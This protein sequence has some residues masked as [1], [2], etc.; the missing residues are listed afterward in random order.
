MEVSS[1]SRPCSRSLRCSRNSCSSSSSSSPTSSSACCDGLPRLVDELALHRVPARGVLRRAVGG[2]QRRARSV[3]PE[4]RPRPVRRAGRVGRHR[5][6]APVGRVGGPRLAR[7]RRGG[8][9]VTVAAGAGRGRGVVGAVVAGRRAGSPCPG[10]LGQA[11]VVASGLGRVGRRRRGPSGLPGAAVL[12]AGRRP[13]RRPACVLPARRGAARRRSAGSSA[14]G[15]RRLTSVAARMCSSGALLG[16]VAARCR[17][18]RRAVGGGGPGS[19]RPSSATGRASG[20]RVGVGGRSTSSRRR[21]SVAVVGVGARRGGGI[22]L[23]VGARPAEQ[24]LDQRPVGRHRLALLLGVDRAALGRFAHRAG[25]P[26]VLHHLG[27]ATEMSS[28]RRSKSSTG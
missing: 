13:G 10:S 9:A 21:S 19:C 27:W 17:G 25:I 16:L 7:R 18:R 4:P 14:S 22:G 20:R 12:G 8:V 24:G 11:A 15:S 5:P 6:A 26:V 1:A 2:H 23:P 28:A 3:A